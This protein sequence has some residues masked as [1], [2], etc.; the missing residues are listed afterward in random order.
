MKN[1]T[2]FFLLVISCLT[3]TEV[4]C[5]SECNSKIRFN[6]KKVILSDE[7]WKAKLTE[8]QFVTLR[9][10]VEEKAFK[11]VYYS[12]EKK[13]VYQCAGC[14]LA[15]FSSKDKFDAKTGRPSFYAPICPQ[16]LAY[17]QKR[18]WFRK[19]TEVLCNRCEGYL[20]E[21]FEDKAEPT[22]KRFSI[23]S[24]ALLFVPK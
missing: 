18:V 8:E 5:Q 2:T 7:D 3:S 11:N 10:G 22:G 21:M 6:G 13:G 17:R 20:G 23:N 4:F 12:T 16:N 15:L 9:G 19:H 1:I 24:A 14:E